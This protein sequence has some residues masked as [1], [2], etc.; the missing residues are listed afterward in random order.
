MGRLPYIFGVLG[1]LLVV[2]ARAD[3]AVIVNPANP[4]Q[5]LTV[6]QVSELYL[7][8]TRNFESSQTAIILD[9]GAEDPLR[10]QFFKNISGMS[11][12]QVTAYWARLRFTGQVKPPQTL[13]G[14]ASVLEFV[15]KNPLAIGYVSQT[16]ATGA[17]VKTVLVLKE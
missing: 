11:I 13:D 9:Q 16:N 3:I 8:R 6:R 12:G 15:R 7:G 1:A 17:N 5:T 10:V 2:S 14:D 4:V